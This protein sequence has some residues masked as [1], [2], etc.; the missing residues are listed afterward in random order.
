MLNRRTLLIA[1]CCAAWWP[2]L[3]SRGARAG[4]L[5][6][7]ASR[8]VAQ[9]AEQ[10]IG[11]VKRKSLSR[12][13]RIKALNDILLQNF[14][15]PAMALFALGTYAGRALAEQRDAYIDAFK[16]YVIEH[17]FARLDQIGD[18]FTIGKAAP[19]GENVAWVQSWVG[20]ANDSNPFRVE[21][22]VRREDGA[23]KIFDVIVQGSSLMWIQRTDFATVLQRNNGSIARLTELM[24][25]QKV[26]SDTPNG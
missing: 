8:F 1:A 13:E 9:V 11:V 18:V 20:G 4:D 17:Y 2:A 10:A 7:E 26:V 19:D 14:D 5:P 3:V 15:V 23:L 21:W 12:E 25:K 24:R 22:R 16:S 6:E